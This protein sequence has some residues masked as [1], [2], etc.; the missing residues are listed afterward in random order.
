MVGGVERCLACGHWQPDFSA[1]LGFPIQNEDALAATP[2]NCP[3]LQ[4]SNG[5]LSNG[6]EPTTGG[7]ECVKQPWG[8]GP[9][10]EG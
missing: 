7:T 2:G 3:I 6:K 9:V 4:F 8:F 10:P 1:A 5:T